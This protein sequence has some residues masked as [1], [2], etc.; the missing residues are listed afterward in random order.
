MQ[1]AID[2]ITASQGRISVILASLVT[3][4][5]VVAVGWLAYKAVGFVY[6]RVA[7]WFEDRADMKEELRR[8]R[9]ED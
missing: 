2:F 7:D 3:F 6:F 1:G 9:G 5:V 8:Y 4:A